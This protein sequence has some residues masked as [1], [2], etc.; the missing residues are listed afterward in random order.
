VE[1]PTEA[2]AATV[3]AE[4]TAQA[5]KRGLLGRPDVDLSKYFIYADQINA[6]M[7][8]SPPSPGEAKVDSP[9]PQ[10]P[11]QGVSIGGVLAVAGVGVLVVG[12][13]LLALGV[14]RGR[15]TP[16][17]T[18]T[19]PS[20]SASL[21]APDAVRFRPTLA[22]SDPEHPAVKWDID[23]P[24]GVAITVDDQAVT[25]T[26]DGKGTTTSD[27]TKECTG[28]SAGEATVEKAI[29]YTAT[30]NGKEVARGNARFQGPAVPLELAAPT[31]QAGD[32]IAVRGR[33]APG[34]EVAVQGA[35]IPT[36]GGAF[37]TTVFVGSTDELVV[38]AALAEHAPRIIRLPIDRSPG[39]G[40]T[41][42]ER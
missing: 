6:A 4:G 15:D 26:A 9:R 27:L 32:R 13:L 11:L 24:A 8:S 37:D 18:A 1:K 19:A 7:K 29:A 41:G 12:G 33:T 38:R 16:R 35:V 34:A 10:P 20:A 3:L 30:M 17:V 39:G 21:L 42:P 5:D 2:P 28:P 14:G 23:A 36:S 31:R 25:L 40:K 22:A